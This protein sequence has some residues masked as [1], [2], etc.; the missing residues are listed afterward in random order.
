MIGYLPKGIDEKELSV[1]KY[2][3]G[4][5]SDLDSVQDVP[6]IDCDSA[7]GFQK[8][9]PDRISLKIH[10]PGHWYRQKRMAATGIGFGFWS[11][12]GLLSMVLAFMNLLL[13]PALDGGYVMFLL[14]RNDYRP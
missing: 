1:V 3:F 5:Q 14:Y 11:M 8:F 2:S 13:I 10:F 12:T 9:S 7:E 4:P 6:S